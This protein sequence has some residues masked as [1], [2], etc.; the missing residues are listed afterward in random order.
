MKF[1]PSWRGFLTV[2]LTMMA[3]SEITIATPVVVPDYSFENT[4]LAPGG[5][6]TDGTVGTNWL[7]SGG[8][9]TYI[10]SITNTLF[11]ATGGGTLPPTA[12][13]TN[14][15]VV[16]EGGFYGYVY[17][18]IGPIQSN[19]TYTLTIA[20]GQSLLGLT[21]QGFIG[22][23]NGT[24][25]FNTL[26]AATAVDNGYSNTTFVAGT[27]VDSTVT[28]TT[29]YKVSGDLTILM[30]GTNLQGSQLLF[31]NVRLNAVPA[32]G[33][34]ALLPGV[35]VPST[36]GIV[37]VYV[38]TPVTL[39]E[40]PTGTAPFTYQWL[41]DNGTGGATFTPI[42]NATNASYTL[43]TGGFSSG[44]VEEYKVVVDGSS[45]SAP[46][47]L[48][49][50]AGVPS[51]TQ[52]TLP[53][54]NAS[55]GTSSDVVGST[56][57]F[58]A[59]FVGNAPLSYQWMVDYGSG[60]VPYPGPAVSTNTSLTITNLQLSDTGNYFLVATDTSGSTSST[61]AAFTVNSVP[62]PDGNGVVISPANQHGLGGQTE[63]TPTW[64]LATNSLISGLLPITNSTGNFQEQ[65]CGGL[66]VLTDGRFGV[67]YPEGNNSADLATIGNPT[68]GAGSSVTYTLPAS[69]NGYDISNITVYGGWSDGG[70]DQQS[71][72]IAYSTI[73][74]PNTFSGS[75]LASAVNYLPSP[76]DLSVPADQ[77]ATR[78]TLTSGTG[79]AMIHNV[80]A[81][82]FFFGIQA[83]G[84]NENGWEGY[85]EIDVSGTPSA[86]APVWVTNMVP[87]TIV[88][89]AGDSETMYVYAASSLP[90]SYQW[91]LDSGGGPVNVS[92]A[93]NSFLTFTNLQPA[94]AGSF[95]VIASAGTESITSLVCAVTVNSANPP[96][97]NNVIESPA[98]QNASSTYF[99]PTWYLAPGS[100][101][102]GTIPV[103]ATP[104]DNAFTGENSGG[105]PILTD[106]TCGST[107]GG[108][109]TSLATC[110][111]NAGQTITYH[112]GG[113]ES[114]FDIT[115]ISVY[116]GWTDGGRNEQAYTI[117]YSTVTAPT[118]Y[119][120]ITAYDSLPFPNPSAANSER[121]T[122][123][124]GTP[125]TPMATHVANL[126]F[127]FTTPNGGGE[128]GYEGYSEIDVYGTNSVAEAVPPNLSQDT[129]PST[130]FDV[131]G[132]QV[133]FTASFNS[134]APMTYQWLYSSTNETNAIAGA[135]GTTLTLSNLQLTN[136]GS[137]SLMASNALGVATSTP[138]GFTVNAVPAPTNNIIVAEAGQ[139]WA[140]TAFTPTWTV[141]A[142]SLIAGTLP[143]SSTD[144]SS[145]DNFV[146]GNG[147]GDCGG[148][149]VLT[150]GLL[151]PIGGG[152]NTAFAAGGSQAGETVTYT[153]AGGGS[154]YNLSRIVVYGGWQDNGRDEQAYTISYSTAKNPSTFTTLE[155]LPNTAAL[156][157]GDPNSTRLT[158]TANGGGYLATDVAA[159][160]FN[161]ATGNGENGWEG[162]SEI[163][164][165][166]ALSLGVNSATISGS[167]LILTGAGGTAGGA[168]S[169]LSTTNLALPL[170]LWTTNVSGTFSGTGTFSNAI[171]IIKSQPGTYFVL[172]TP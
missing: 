35:S 125:G 67:L 33:P 116:G 84:Y 126:M 138:S 66:P 160:E 111:N 127:N 129:L 78:I 170:S 161:F 121:I 163:G 157:G 123:T 91:Q 95:T 145:T 165:Y 52:D 87:N 110:G 100:L 154:G 79:G 130:G 39:S 153:L 98:Y 74:A 107:G 118:V 20:V 37:G 73:A 134:S 141:P 25:P 64:V 146:N 61:E 113:S 119:T 88:D 144:A 34:L 40:D 70:R 41:T 27:F 57:K 122:Y 63:F 4:V 51:I 23:V 46:V 28:F 21:G 159:V 140:G 12:N 143:T 105:L 90:I 38:G 103:S 71:Y 24:T 5:T 171:P 128:N 83:G 150:D 124:P 168:Y 112:L 156:T 50:S 43:A 131:V 18:D 32:S 92:G 54:G 132:S 109:N 149:P 19:T 152:V 76:N 14:Y 13:G 135:T 7:S 97:G 62:A 48:T 115:N 99:Y 3:T 80:A 139:T 167:N 8:G 36:N 44:N 42:A 169:L 172:K 9:G 102:A 26:L 85:A 60:P 22:L 166:G 30:E 96:D 15:V 11:Q 117:S 45:T 162:Y 82:Q 77:S 53:S 16:N 147:G 155:A 158:F 31:D 93:T 75:L 1:T 10:Q 17:Q 6:S 56:V 55:T 89:E 69:A 114:G 164:I 86:A 133:T 151:G 58:T 101:I 2:L 106:G 104:S 120:T 59:A 136:S 65:G 148:V 47:T 72:T 142:G 108:V 94:D 137:Y 81:L 49:F 29:G 68:S